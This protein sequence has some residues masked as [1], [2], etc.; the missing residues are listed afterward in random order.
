[1]SKVVEKLISIKADIG[2]A[3]KEIKALFADLLESQKKSQESQTKLNDSVKDLGETSKKS[4]KGIQSLAQG[5]KGVGLAIKA[6]GI[7]LLLSALDTLKEVF[8]SNQQVV[9]AFATGMNFLKIAFNDL[10]KFIKDNID[11][12]VKSFK[13]VFDDPQQAIK[14]LGNAIKD[15]L[16][17]RF[18]SFID[19]LGYA[20][21]AIKKLF[22]GDFK[23]ALEDAKK[24]GK[25]LVDVYTGVNDS[26]DKSVDFIKN[27]AGAIVDYTK[28][29]L[30]SAEALTKLEK[31]IEAQALAQERLALQYETA[32]EKQRQ[33]RDDESSAITD[34]IAA[35]DKLAGI[36]VKQ[37]EAEKATVNARIAAL[38]LQNQLLGVTTE[39]TNEIYGLQTQLIDVNNKIV[40]QQSE[41]LVNATALN[42]ELKELNQTSIDGANTRLLSEKN[43]T[44]ALIKDDTDR[45]EAQRKTIIEEGR[46]QQEALTKKRDQYK[47]GTQAYA[48][49]EQERLNAKQSTDQKLIT[50][51]KT[52]T[53][54][55][56]SENV[57]R[58]NRLAADS[59]LTFEAREEA[60]AEQRRLANEAV[61]KS[62][63]E[64]IEVL[65]ELTAREKALD[66]EKYQSKLA[67]LNGIQ[68][69]AGQETALGKAVLI[70]KQL[71]A[72]QE[73]ILD[74]KK[75][76]A[77]ARQAAVDATVSGASA[78]AEVASGAAKTV[79]A[80]PFPA[81]IPLILG[82]AI[83][84]A[85]IITSVIA[86][87]KKVKGAK[88]PAADVSGGG[89]GGAPLPQAQFNVVGSSGTNQLA[90]TIGAQQQQPIEAYVVGS[91]VTTQQ[92]L[93]R[94]RVKN[95]T[96]L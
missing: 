96:F 23:G 79:A 92:E 43:F 2:T 51:D 24:G 60:L 48:D 53:E 35:N 12:V 86:A 64:K 89:G 68:A 69:L 1:M 50:S 36:L 70:A 95:S 93:D 25:E 14:D 84:G 55:L 76:I 67:L 9:D 4:E 5:F 58:L 41:Q 42:K 28:K 54:T 7:G 83:Q 38:Q 49:A 47:E 18:Q 44:D 21:S 63:E 74:I 75:S 82:Y 66:E 65:A 78:G 39:R 91:S 73:L 26:F 20:A 88:A 71:L 6:M 90:S 62:E 15:N 13:A 33:L 22:Q 61:Y 40:G 31:N 37:G 3:T 52:T 77:K 85:A 46:I 81:N 80:A 10:F 32:A 72:A 8:M 29:T 17:E 19:T 56:V 27:A 11:P 16:I 45:L 59:D 30:A 87:V 57:S 34:R 94:N